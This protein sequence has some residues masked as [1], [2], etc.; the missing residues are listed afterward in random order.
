[1]ETTIV[2]WGSIGIM[3]KKMET[4]IYLSGP[5]TNQNHS[6]THQKAQKYS[7]SV[8]TS[9]LEDGSIYSD[10]KPAHGT[11]SSYKH[12]LGGLV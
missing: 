6:S 7:E 3:E 11:T 5:D 9:L 8:V 10:L 2:Y 4:T 12:A 1:M